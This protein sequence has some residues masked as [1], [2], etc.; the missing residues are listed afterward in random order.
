[1]TMILPDVCHPPVNYLLGT[2]VDHP[3]PAAATT[4]TQAVLP[5]TSASYATIEH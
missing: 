4:Q 1:M 2:P 5:T 3:D